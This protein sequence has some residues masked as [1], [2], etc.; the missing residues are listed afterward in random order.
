MARLLEVRGLTAFY[1]ETQALFGIDFDLEEGGITALLGANGAGKTTTLRALCGAVK[2]RGSVR[3]AD[4]A[5]EGRA[6][7][8]IARMGVAHVPDGR[9]TFS[10][11]T[12]EENLKLGAYTRRDRA[13]VAADMKRMYARFPRLKERRAQQAGTLSGGEQ[14]ML[15]ISR[16]LMLRPRLLL[17]DEPSF[18]LAP[19]MVGEIFAILGEINRE[20]GV[21]MLLVEQNAS[22]ALELAGHAYL[23]ETGAIA[24]SGPSAALRRDETVR[25]A[26]LGY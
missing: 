22:L 7:E 16:A 3:F 5:I 4:Q 6:T 10:A 18:G 15:A 8:D 23:L 14:Q 11:L 21:S 12:V 24:L 13:G 20:E 9:G 26:Y 19:L 17:L 2:M 1:G 25:K